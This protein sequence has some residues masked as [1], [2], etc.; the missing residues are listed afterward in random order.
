M[1]SIPDWGVTPFADGQERQQIATA[2]DAYNDTAKKICE[3]HYI[4]FIDITTSQRADG[5]KPEFL[6]AD[7]LHPSGKEY[8]KWARQLSVAILKNLQA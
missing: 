3:Q 1:L 5:N 8:A 7:G 4:V 2:I 6:A